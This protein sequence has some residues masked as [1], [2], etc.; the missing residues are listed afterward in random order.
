MMK[1][2]MSA[3]S[4]SLCCCIYFSH[5]IWL[6]LSLLSASHPLFSLYSSLPPLPLSVFLPYPGHILRC[7]EITQLIIRHFIWQPANY[8]CTQSPI[9]LKVSRIR[10]KEGK[11]RKS[12]RKRTSRTEKA[13][14]YCAAQQRN[15]RLSLLVWPLDTWRLETLCL[16]VFRAIK[17]P[18]RS[19]EQGLCDWLLTSPTTHTHTPQLSSLPNP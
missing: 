17:A 10:E 5:F 15:S 18:T 6:S 14:S 13:P 12:W 7:I 16:C 1:P 4:L 2:L 3:L 9:H 11:E 19:G 8:V